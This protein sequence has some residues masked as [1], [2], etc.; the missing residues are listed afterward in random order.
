MLLARY[1][2]GVE[3]HRDAKIIYA[4]FLTPHRV[5]STCR[6]STGGLHDDLG[7]LYNHQSCE[8]SGHNLSAELHRLAVEQPD[9][10]RTVIAQ[11]YDLPSVGC[12]TM[13]T[14]ANMQ[15]A[16]IV[17][18]TFRELEVVAV[19][20]AGV[21]TNAGRA[22]DPASYHEVAGQYEALHAPQSGTI[23]IMLLLNHELA[24]GTLVEA[25][26]LVTEAKTATLQELNVPSCY[27]DGLATGTG[28]D[29]VGLAARLGGI[30]LRG[31]QKHTKLGE[32]LAHV[33]QAALRQA[34]ARQNGLTPVGQ[35]RTMALLR[36]LG[37]TEAGLSAAI[38]AYLNHDDAALLQRNLPVILNDPPTVAA[39]MALLHLRDQ[40]RWGVLP[41]SCMPEL[42]STYAAQLAAAVSGRP[43]RSVAYQQT[44]ANAPTSLAPAA[45][46]DLIARAFALGFSEKWALSLE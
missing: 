38:C 25:V 41:H 40:L 12:A 19:V 35:C 3:L 7:Y 16:A 30:A 22:G 13:G 36:R 33:V 10:Y 31:A 15:T 27:A 44:L 17:H 29:Q 37:A 24:P 11:R 4:R 28:T 32:L 46:L 2:D 14:A 39:V 18:E 6:S 8:P 1:Y 26:T 9:E 43:P 42:F 34:L 5:I 45:M 21:E 20:T 23:V